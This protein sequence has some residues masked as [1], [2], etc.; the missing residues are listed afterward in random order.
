MTLTPEA[1]QKIARLSRLH[2]SADE[3]T[4]HQNNLNAI[5]KWIDQLQNVDVSQ[6]S[7]TV[8]GQTPLM[9]ERTDMVTAPNRV[10]DVLK[11]APA[12]M[13]DMFSVPKVVE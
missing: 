1:I 4:Y 3:V 10:K 6:V 2:L 11:N 8:D 12:S 13:H 5:F 7:L 9:H